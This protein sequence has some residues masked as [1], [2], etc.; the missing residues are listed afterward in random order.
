MSGMEKSMFPDTSTIITCP[1][2]HKHIFIAERTSAR[3]TLRCLLSQH[4]D[5][6]DAH[7]ARTTQSATRYKTT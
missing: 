1:T 5:E 4:T 3:I 7:D 6:T 2:A